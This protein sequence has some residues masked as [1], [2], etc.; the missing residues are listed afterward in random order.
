MWLPP[1]KTVFIHVPKTAGNFVQS[2]FI[3]NGLSDE[4]ITTLGHQDGHD[5]FGI[6][7]KMTKS[8]HQS[9]RSYQKAFGRKAWSELEVLSIWRDPRDRLVSLYLSP[10]RH[11]EANGKIVPP[12]TYDKSEFEWLVNESKSTTQFLETRRG[13]LPKSLNLIAF[14]NLR[15]DLER[16]LISKGHEPAIPQEKRNETTS[17]QLFGEMLADKQILKIVERSHHMADFELPSL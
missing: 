3:E 12:R 4:E 10:H 8:K 2:F 13:N 11:A 16:F 14:S 7:G 6:V 1:L 17:K 5:R 15:G 9:V